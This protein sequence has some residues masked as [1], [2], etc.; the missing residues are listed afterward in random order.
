MPL[1]ILG[2]LILCLGA[3]RR[4][5]LLP[6][7]VP[8]GVLSYFLVTMV[9]LATAATSPWD[10]VTYGPLNLMRDSPDV[11]CRLGGAIPDQESSSKSYSATLASAAKKAPTPAPALATL[12]LSYAERVTIGAATLVFC[13]G[14]IAALGAVL[15]L[16]RRTLR[17]D[18]YLVQACGALYLRYEEQYY[19]WEVIILLRKLLLVLITR[20]LSGNQSAQI[21]GCAVV[22]GGALALQHSCKPSLSDALDTLEEH[23]LVACVAIVAL[24]AA[25]ASGLDPQ[26]ISALY[27]LT[28]AASAA[29]LWRDM[30]AV[31]LESDPA[32]DAAAAV[33]SIPPARTGVRVV[34]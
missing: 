33:V 17:S 27:F 14:A 8:S 2:G 7:S 22:L 25:S 34:V 3:C 4:T 1:L 20:V 26:A 6:A 28:M 18:K 13:T 29:L 15:Y 23:T 31:W 16:R 12:T 19:Y 32:S 10:C 11:T 30:R 24:G 21:A 9:A 5:A